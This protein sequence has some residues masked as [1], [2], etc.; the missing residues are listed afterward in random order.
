M[1]LSSIATPTP[2]ALDRTRA[3]IF[4]VL[5]IASCFVIGLVIYDAYGAR[6]HH[7]HHA[8]QL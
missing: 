5:V 8:E 7:H 2:L 4:A 6:H 3:L 1:P